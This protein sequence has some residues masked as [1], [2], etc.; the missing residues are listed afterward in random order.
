MPGMLSR[1]IYFVKL[2]QCITNTY[3]RFIP[4]GSKCLQP[5]ALICCKYRGPKT[6]RLCSHS[7][8][9]FTNCMLIFV[10]KSSPGYCRG[11]SPEGPCGTMPLFKAHRCLLF[12]HL[13]CCFII[14]FLCFYRCFE[15]LFEHLQRPQVDHRKNSL[16]G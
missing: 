15:I 8:V 12:K 16:R 9:V 4:L 10:V 1:C 7:K 5:A 2:L 13:L 11:L 6:P 14:S 3:Y